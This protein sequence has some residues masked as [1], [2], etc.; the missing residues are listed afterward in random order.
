MIIA[1]ISSYREGALLDSCVESARRTGIDTVCVFEG[2]VGPG[3]EL[4]H[5]GPGFEQLRRNGIW[6]HAGAWESDAAKRT[7]M[8]D[9]AKG[10]HERTAT[11]AGFANPDQWEPLWVLWL[12]GDELL[13]W[14][15]YLHDHVRRAE[16]EG[17]NVGGFP[18]RLVELDGSVAKCHGKVVRGDLIARYLESSYQVELTTGMVV[19]L[20]NEPICGPGGTPAHW[21]D[22]EIVLEDL[23]E[24][25][26]PVA[27]EPHLLHRS[28]LRDPNR[29]VERLHAA[30]R[31]FYDDGERS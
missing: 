22:R 11:R 13:L 9:W 27:G 2:P 16:Q 18:L 14:G 7:A 30:E 25:R 21:G 31:G 23:A 1:L 3:A 6:T 20:P 5:T 12:D 10:Y 29:G 24:L 4:E 15:E 19:A 26:P 17:D 8:L 28:M